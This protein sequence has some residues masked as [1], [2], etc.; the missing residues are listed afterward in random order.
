MSN[1][2]ITINI[3]YD[4]SL[5]MYSRKNLIED[6]FVLYFAD[7]HKAQSNTSNQVIKF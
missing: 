3:I 6:V 5:D 2:S 4:I 1:L 7:Y